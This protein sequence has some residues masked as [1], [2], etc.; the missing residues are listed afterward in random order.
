VL[1]KHSERRGREDSI[2]T[3]PPEVKA[4]KRSA[5]FSGSRLALVAG[6]HLLASSPDPRWQQDLTNPVRRIGFY[7]AWIFVF[8]RFGM[9]HEVLS[10]YFN[11]TVYLLAA[12]GAP[13]VF[14]AVMT[15]GL[16]RTLRFHT[17]SY[18]LGFM[19]WLVL[20]I[21]LSSWRIGSLSLVSSYFR[22]QFVMLFVIGGLVMG[23][24]EFRQM[25][26]AV[27]LGALTNV[28]T[29]RLFQQQTADGDGL[30]F[31]G[32]SIANINDFA[33]HLLLVLCFVLLVFLAAEKNWVTRMS[34]LGL[35]G[36][37]LYAVIRTGSRGALVALALAAVY[38][39]ARASGPMRAAGIIALPLLVTLAIGLL[40]KSTLMRYATLFT[41]ASEAEDQAAVLS[42]HARTYLLQTS[43]LFSLQHPLL[44]VGPGEFEDY[45]AKTAKEAG[46]RA[47][48]QVSH[49]TYTQISSEAGIPALLFVIAALVS[50]YRI[51]NNVFKQ[52][53]TQVVFQPIMMAS[54]CLMLAMVTFCSAIFFLSLAYKFYLPALSG[55]AIALSCAAQ[56]EFAK[57]KPSVAN[58][59]TPEDGAFQANT[60]R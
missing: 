7:I 44:G 29:A 42:A 46:R 1:Q 26:H 2:P 23:W 41:E 47:A 53:R 16:R 14:L 25:T 17:A 43:A 52:A 19:V 33:A 45:E 50:T 27:A 18:W 40:P 51:L 30:R 56:A 58:R 36:A 60:T 22:T 38:A 34:A 59:L 24:K 10:I 3:T 9:I 35:L 55:F 37:G 48:W 21:P 28:M 13:C 6:P 39:L 8:V 4:A 31:Q 11:G 32:G 5:A 54:F 57:V 20:A 49:N 12:L 15:G